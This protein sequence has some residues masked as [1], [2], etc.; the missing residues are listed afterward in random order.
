MLVI[1]LELVPV[2]MEGGLQMAWTY[3]AGLRVGSFRVTEWNWL[4]AR[5][6]SLS[7]MPL[8]HA[9]QTILLASGG[10]IRCER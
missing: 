5:S 10:L 4:V 2:D 6:S 1:D 7:G 9:L 3:C 8:H